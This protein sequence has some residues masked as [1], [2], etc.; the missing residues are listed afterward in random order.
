MLVKL[1]AVGATGKLPDAG[2]TRT[3]AAVGPPPSENAVSVPS[4]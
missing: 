4:A 2:K 3:I 1:E